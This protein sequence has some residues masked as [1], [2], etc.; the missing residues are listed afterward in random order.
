MNDE[1]EYVEKHINS[2]EDIVLKNNIEKLIVDYKKKLHRLK[3]TIKQS[4]KNQ[5]QIMKMNSELDKYKNSLEQRVEEEVL[6]REESD[7]I[8]F[9]QARLASMGEMID[10]IAHQWAQPINTISLQTGNLVYKFKNEL[11]DEESIEK[12]EFK[13]NKQINH[14]ADTLNTFR[15]FARPAGDDTTFTIYDAIDKAL[16]LVEDEFKKNTINIKVNKE[17]D[18]DLKGDINEFIHLILNIINNSKDAFIE[19]N[20]PEKKIELNIFAHSD[21][22]GISIIDNA[23]GI[24]ADVINDIFEANVTTKGKN[25][26]TGIGLYMSTLIAEKFHSTLSV[27]NYNDGTKFTLNMT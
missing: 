11:L 15:N 26:G 9:N 12:Y 8:L 1:L 17:A 7:K 16:V 18:I 23:G 21:V 25:K 6:K 19:K 5:L 3:I 24:P 14:M 10:A 2:L 22:K 13:I 20:M 4:D 27:E